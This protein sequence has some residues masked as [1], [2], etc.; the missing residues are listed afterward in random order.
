MQ[1]ITTKNVKPSKSTDTPRSIKCTFCNRVR[2]AK[3]KCFQ[4]K[5]KE[6]E[7][8]TAKLEMSKEAVPEG[9]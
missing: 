9:N 6:A 8:T 7:D 1:Y 5:L 3:E 4:L 2:H